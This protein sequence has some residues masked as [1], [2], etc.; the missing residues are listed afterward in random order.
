MTL[1]EECRSGLD[2]IRDFYEAQATYLTSGGTP[3]DP[4]STLG[5]LPYENLLTFSYSA[6]Q[7]TGD[8]SVG[9]SSELVAEFSALTR[10]IEMASATKASL[11][12]DAASESLQEADIYAQSSGYHAGVL[13]GA[14][15]TGSKS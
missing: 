5:E 3:P 15:T 7:E 8:Y 12:T 1:I 9:L 6:S 4:V 10:E 2:A 13:G 11:Y 14:R